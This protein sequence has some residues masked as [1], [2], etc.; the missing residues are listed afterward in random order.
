MNID[1]L[2]IRKM[3]LQ[4]RDIG[5][6]HVLRCPRELLRIL[7]G[8]LLFFS[9]PRVISLAQRFPILGRQSDSLRRSEMVL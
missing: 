4:C 9:E 2:L 6:G 7:Q 1:N 3:F 8:C 5:V